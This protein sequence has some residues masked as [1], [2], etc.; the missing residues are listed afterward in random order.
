VIGAV[1]FALLFPSGMKAQTTVP[2]TRGAPVAQAASPQ[3]LFTVGE[4][5]LRENR[6][7]EAERNFRAV[8]AADPRVAGAYANLG[9]IHMRRKQWPQA[10]TMLHKAEKLAPAVAGIRLNIGLAYF[11]KNDFL[12]AIKPFESVVKQAP[13]S[14]QARYLL[15]LCYFFNDRWEDTIAML[16]PLW[17]QASNQL[18]YLY[19]LARAAEKAKDAALEEKAQSRLVEIGQGTPEYRLIIGKAHYNRGEY[20]DAVRELEMAAQADPKLPFVHFNLGLA[21][22]RKQE[23]E[24]ARAEFKKDLELEPDVAF[25]YEQLGNVES[26]L[27]HEDE[28][29]KNYRQAV[30]LDRRLVGPHMG[31]AKIEERRRNHRLALDELDEVIRLDSGNASARYLRGQVLVRMGREREGRAELATATKMLNQQRS[32]RQ[33]DLE[34]GPAPSPELAREPE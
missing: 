19:V 25:T 17:G 18:N 10:L 16:E 4:A 1:F 29:E 3:K 21:Y 12:A 7:D 27:Q 2:V 24:R 11:R 5:A 9:V 34:E 22:L 13:D 14:Y 23:H 26:T 20:D 33:K 28:A 15:G 31:L 8:L 32:A 30:K 6:L